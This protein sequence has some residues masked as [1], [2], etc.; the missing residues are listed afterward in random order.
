MYSCYLDFCLFFIASHVPT[1]NQGRKHQRLL[2]KKKRK[3]ENQQCS[4]FVKG[5]DKNSD[6][7]SDLQRTFSPYGTV[8]DVYVDKNKVFNAFRLLIIN[9]QATIICSREYVTRLYGPVVSPIGQNTQI[10]VLT[11]RPGEM[12]PPQ[13]PKVQVVFLIMKEH[14]VYQSLVV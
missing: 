5:F 6:V 8:K 10:T 13:R 11:N 2:L 14:L 3:N 1:H 4:I 12:M 7:A 9:L